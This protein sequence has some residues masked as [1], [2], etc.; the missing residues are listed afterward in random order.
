MSAPV[1]DDVPQPSDSQQTQPDDVPSQG[2]TEAATTQL[3]QWEA[4]RGQV[5]VKSSDSDTWL[6]LVDVAVASG[7]YGRVNE[8]YEALLEAYPNT[9][10][11]QIA[12]INH[13]LDSS[14]ETK[15]QEAEGLF[16]RFLRTSSFV[17][18]WKFYLAY[19]RRLNGGPN[20]RDTVRMA[21]E[22]ALNHIGHDKESSEIWTD[23]IQFLKSGETSNTWEEGQKMDAVRKAYQ[24]AVQIPM[25]NVKRLWEEYQEFENNL[26]KITAKKL[27]SDLTPAHMQARTVLTTLQE[28]L[29]VL[30]PPAPSTKTA[31]WLPRVPNFSAGDKALVGRWRIYLKWEEGNPLEIEEK[32]KAQ[33]HTRLQGVYRK[34]LV[35]M[36]FFSEIWYMAYVWYMTLSN[37]TS[38]PEQKRKDRK[39][40]ALNILKAGIQANPSSFVLNFAYAEA[41]ETDKNFEEVH[42]TFDKFLEVLRKDLE[43]VETRVNTGNP[44]LADGS[45]SQSNGAAADGGQTQNSSQSSEGGASKSKELNDRRTEYGVAWIVYMRFARRAENL[46]S[47]RAVFGKAR[48]DRWTP[49]EVF[50]AAALM[51]YHCTKATEVAMRIFEKGLE[52][53][54]DEVE[55]A[56]RYLGFLISINDDSNSRALFERVVNIFPADRARPIWDRW[57][58]Y[59]YQFGSLEAAQSLEKRISEIYPNDPPIKRFAERHKYLGTDAIAVHDLGFVI[60]RGNGNGSS[61]RSNASS[62]GRTET[63]SSVLNITSSQPQQSQ[64]SV[65]KRAPSPDHR[66]RDDSRGGSTDYGPPSKRARANSPQQR[67]Y[68]DRDERWGRRRHGS[69]SGWDRERERESTARRPDREKEEEKSVIPNVLS[70]FV[71]Q[72][73]AASSFDGPV[74][75]TDDLMQ[76]LRGAMIPSST[77]IRARSPGPPPVMRGGGRPP[78][79]YSP[80]QGPGG[81]RRGRY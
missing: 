20:A 2:P 1:P 16:K 40:E 9:P 67:T 44:S 28:H 66:R 48:R 17:E 37:D 55:F 38:L 74:F 15:Y 31:V 78:P 75:R 59:E 79:D 23:Y 34:A 5:R 29:T 80:Y 63:Q 3:Q 22:F 10:S 60:S 70:W 58:R 11:A 6:K 76:L 45:Q 4:L 81:G 64:G 7:D 18:L 56:L 61:G 41:L 33:L 35:R 39:E 43:V 62:L 13:I 27:I 52:T 42:A 24:R 8:T 46:K 49:W 72:L 68:P 69:P 14:R 26:N 25:D 51:E 12:Y 65:T 53:F 36:R 47:A 73:P 50:E 32:D 71:G 19:V 21:Y 77:G 54:P 57:A 30:I